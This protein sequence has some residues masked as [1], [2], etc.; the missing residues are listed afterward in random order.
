MPAIGILS[1]P[2]AQPTGRLPFE[3]Y[4]FHDDRHPQDKANYIDRHNRHVDTNYVSSGG[5]ERM[6]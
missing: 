2:T 4:L 1:F 6:K 5:R 3:H